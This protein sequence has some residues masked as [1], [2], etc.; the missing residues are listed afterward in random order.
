[1]RFSG[2]Q[3]IVREARVFQRIGYLEHILGIENGVCAKGDVA[4]RLQNVDAHP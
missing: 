3:R 2:H 4:G 1:M